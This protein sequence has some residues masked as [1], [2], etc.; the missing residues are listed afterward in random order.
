MSGST[1]EP[2][3]LLALDLRPLSKAGGDSWEQVLAAL[4]R[5]PADGVLTLEAADPPTR[6]VAR[7]EERDYRVS[8]REGA[9][10]LWSGAV[11]P[12]GAPEIAD[13]RDLVAPEPLERVLEATATLAP[14]VAFLAR[15]PRYPRLL[16]PRLHERGLEFEVREE[17]DGTALVHV[18]RPA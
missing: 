6:L 14:G 9:G 16:L 15:V 1:S 18:R 10:N 2:R 3:Y 7:L 5:L 13:F 4:E 11:Q 12:A 17:R 8:V